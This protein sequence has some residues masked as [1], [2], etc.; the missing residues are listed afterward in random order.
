MH[1]TPRRYPHDVLFE[2]RLQKGLANGSIHLAFRR[3]RRP[4]VVGGRRYRSPI[5]LIGV[6]DVSVVN[7]ADISVADAQAAGYGSVAELLAD[8]RGPAD[9]QILFRVALHVLAQADPRDAL[10]M[11][12]ALTEADVRQ[13]QLRLASLDRSRAWTDA[14]LRAIHEQPGK[15][16]ADLASALGWQDVPAFK[17]HVRKLKALGL[18][19]SLLVGYRLAPRGEAFLRS[20]LDCKRDAQR[21]PDRPV[22]LG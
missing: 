19:Q 11:D 13:L 14:T 17:V 3:W 12:T 22:Q 21:L 1:I 10:A 2:P 7:S 4:Q 6:D 5:G 18:T 9:S 8:L 20:R 16:A 15:R